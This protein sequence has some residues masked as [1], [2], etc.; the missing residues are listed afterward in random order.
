MWGLS[1]S[2]RLFLS[3]SSTSLSHLFLAFSDAIKL[4]LT[5]CPHLRLGSLKPPKLNK[6]AQSRLVGWP[7]QHPPRFHALWESKTICGKLRC[8]NCVRSN[9]LGPTGLRGSD[10]CTEVTRHKDDFSPSAHVHF[11][12]VDNA[13][14]HSELSKLGTILAQCGNN[15]QDSS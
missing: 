3:T 10:L 12:L 9:V 7:R 11:T 4:D 15:V 13:Y 5:A 6:L 8:V 2:T 1:P 14:R